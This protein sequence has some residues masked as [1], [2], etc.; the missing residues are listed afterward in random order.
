MIK[1]SRAA[2]IGTVARR[3]GINIETIRY[4]ERIGL[5]SEPGRTGGG[6]RIYDE[7]AISRLAFIKHSRELGFSI[8]DIREL[9]E[10][11]DG[12]GFS[13]GDIHRLTTNHISRVQAKIA[14]LKKIENVL[15]DMAAKCYQGE[16]PECPII[17]A[18]MDDAK[19]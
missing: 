10:M 9:L 7:T 17:D 16:V 18:L 15:K 14:N 8:G 2:T 19:Y 3:T 6:N 5:V 4:Y 13:C 11:V 12:N 1:K